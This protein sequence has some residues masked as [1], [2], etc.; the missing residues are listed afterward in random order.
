MSR[1]WQRSAQLGEITE[2]VRDGTHASF[3]R[4]TRGKP[5]L[6]AKNITQ[7]GEIVWDDSDSLVSDADYRVIS[8]SFQVTR[9]DVLLTIVGSIGRVALFRSDEA[10]AFQRSVAVIR[11]RRDLISGHFLAHA[12]RMHRV[13]SDLFRRANATAQAGV[14]LGELEQVLVPVPP[15]AEQQRIVEILDTADDVIRLTELLVTKQRTL[16]AQVARDLFTGIKRFEDNTTLEEPQIASRW[17]YGRLPGINTIPRG[18]R[19]VR[20][21]DH[22]KLESGHT[23]S[24]DVPSYW[25]GD[26]PW[27]SLHDTSKLDRHV[28]KATRYSVTMEGINNSSARL[29]PPGTVAF[30][31]TATVGKCVILGR[32]MATSQD[33]ACYICGPG[34]INR[35]I[36]HLFRFMQ[37]V[38]NSL[39][40]GST[41][42]TVYMPIFENLQILLPPVDEQRQIADALDAF[43]TVLDSMTLVARKQRVIKQGLMDDLLTGRMR[44]GVSA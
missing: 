9:G 44:V 34:V 32:A 37:S 22:A 39:A 6:S 4:V 41:H 12:L 33:F 3:Q 1:T 40:S 13:Q 30:S 16:K 29:L 18:W 2:F 42:Q 19:L 5:F 7:D 15:L 28:I 27:L 26:I 14:Y 23:P 8:R 10:V 31:R 21:V 24:R 17:N 38:W 43:D 35:Y 11:P 25:G 20:L 36:L